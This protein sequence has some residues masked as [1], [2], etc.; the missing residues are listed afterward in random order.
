MFIVFFSYAFMNQSTSLSPVTKQ[1]ITSSS[2]QRI[3]TIAS[4]DFTS[5]LSGT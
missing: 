2:R 4:S 3:S 1:H 5:R